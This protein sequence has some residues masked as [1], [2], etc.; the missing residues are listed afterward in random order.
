[1]LDFLLGKKL[2]NNIY[3][4][5][6]ESIS[7]EEKMKLRKLED[8]VQELLAKGNVRRDVTVVLTSR[9]VYNSGLRSDLA[10]VCF[11]T[12]RFLCHYRA[13][14]NIIMTLQRSL[15]CKIFINME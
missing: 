4:K 8:S 2:Q 13:L 10:Q 3:L 5:P 15:H 14:H 6:K 1:M 7:A 12:L 11:L 9:G